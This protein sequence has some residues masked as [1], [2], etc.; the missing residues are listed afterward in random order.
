MIRTKRFHTILTIGCALL[1]WTHNHGNAQVR[2]QEWGR[3][4]P[5]VTREFPTS[6]P[7][8]TADFDGNGTTDVF[9]MMRGAGRSDGTP[10]VYLNDGNG[11][12][13]VVRGQSVLVAGAGS[14]ATG[15]FDG[16]GNIDIIGGTEL[17]TTAA[18]AG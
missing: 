9:V 15:D 4:I 8:Y 11:V 17:P 18:V 13:S 10:H 14:Y 2:F 16:D 12:F 3:M 7:L 6:S 1:G 5:Q